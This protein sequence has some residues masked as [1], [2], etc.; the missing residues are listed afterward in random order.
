[1]PI[2]LQGRKSHKDDGN[3]AVG[4]PTPNNDPPFYLARYHVY[5][6][7]GVYFVD[8][9]SYVGCILKV[10]GRTRPSRTSVVDVA[11]TIK[12]AV[13]VGDIQYYI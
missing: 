8:Q 9:T 10:I 13:L 5:V 7:V 6:T 1:M 11:I 3:D 4:A 12:I 2:R